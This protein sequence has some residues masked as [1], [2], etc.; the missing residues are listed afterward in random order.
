MMEVRR[1]IWKPPCAGASDISMADDICDMT[2][3]PALLPISLFGSL[4][5]PGVGLVQDHPIEWIELA[6]PR[7][8]LEHA[9]GLGVARL[10]ALADAGGAEVDVLGVILVL[11]LRREQPHHMHDGGT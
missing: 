3:L 7:R 8:L 6:I 9:R 11:K 5:H 1:R 4:Q 2:A 10:P